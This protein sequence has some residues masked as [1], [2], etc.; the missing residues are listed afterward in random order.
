MI[1]LLR[2]PSPFHPPLYAYLEH[3]PCLTEKLLRCAVH[4]YADVLQQL[5]LSLCNTSKTKA[6]RRLKVGVENEDEVI[7]RLMLENEACLNATGKPL[8][9]AAEKGQ[10]ELV[11]RLLEHGAPVDQQSSFGLTALHYAALYGHEVILRAALKAGAN[12]EAKTSNSQTPLHYAAMGGY[13]MMAQLLV[14]SGADIEARTTDD[15][16][17]LSQAALRGCISAVRKLLDHGADINACTDN[18]KTALDLATMNG[19]TELVQLLVE[20]GLRG[21][22]SE[23]S[24]DRVPG[25]LSGWLGTF[26][27]E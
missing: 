1:R 14:K 24:V 7:V 19:H 20:R 11:L 8:L 23:G 22:K 10:T 6:G 4:G 18:G 15:H 25:G 12:V 16:T 21:N 17:A 13:T 26:G 2:E 27:G 5:L 3:D 9:C